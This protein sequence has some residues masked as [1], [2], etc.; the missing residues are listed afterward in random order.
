MLEPAD[1]RS[2]NGNFVER[3]G[4]LY[5]TAAQ[6]GSDWVT[7][8][9][10]VIY[11]YTPATD[12]YT[13]LLDLND[14]IRNP[15]WGMVEAADGRL[16][17]IAD[18]DSSHAWGSLASGTLYAYDIATNTLEQRI[19]LGTLPFNSTGRAWPALMAAS[20][21]RLYGSFEQGLFE[22][23]P[24]TNTLA[25][26]AA[27][28]DGGNG[29]GPL[30]ALIE[31]CRKPNYKPTTSTAFAVCNGSYFTYDLRN[32]N[33]TGV[34]WRH[35]GTVAPEQTGQR[36][37]FDAIA[38]GDAGTW[39]CTLTN[40]C[41]TTQPPA[42]TITVGAGM[43]TSPVITG[44]TVLCGTNDAVVLSAD[45]SGVW[46]TGEAGTSITVTAPGD[47][48]LHTQQ[49]CG[50]AFSNILHVVHLDSVAAQV[51]TM[52]GGALQDTITW[53]PGDAI[54]LVG[55]GPGPWGALPAGTWSTGSEAPS[56][57]VTEQGSYSV[58][59]ANAC[60]ADT[61]NTVHV[62]PP[63]P[64]PAPQVVYTDV[65]GATAD[66]LLCTGESVAIGAPPGANYTLLQHGDFVASLN[67]ISTYATSDAGTYQVVASG[68]CQF[69]SDTVTISIT[70]DDAVPTSATI[71]P[72]TDVL[73]GCDQ[74]EV[75]LGHAEPQ[76]Y[77]LWM[78]G[79]GM[80]QQ[81]TTDHLLVD[82]QV[83]AYALI[84]Y[85]GCGDGAQDVITLSPLPAP[86]VTFDEPVMLWCLIDGPIPLTT[87][88]PDGG[89]YSG[90]GV[91][92]GY[93][94]PSAAGIG[95]HVLTYSVT[96]G[97]CTGYATDTI[98]VEACGGVVAA[99]RPLPVELH[100]VPND[101]TFIL[102]MGDTGGTVTL[103]AMDGKRIG[104]AFRLPP[105]THRLDLR[106]LAAGTYVVHVIADDGRAA[107]PRFVVTP[108]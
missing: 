43:A 26:R 70:V 25:L 15:V 12:T 94:T 69:T 28:P 60:N 104:P 10:G 56:I 14:S 27:L 19:D 13:K 45:M 37:T 39:A 95:T 83:Q 86:E 93:F 81:D 32:V 18:N 35:N 47:H 87:G 40:A 17:G 106:P 48:Q 97:T 20:N 90:P 108:P 4:L 58:I 11:S 3:D 64:P 49:A 99:A 9:K 2:P 36:L 71:L 107:F 24:A 54:E 75:Y 68:V 101:G 84:S 82:W 98:M 66:A 103:L 61:S 96:I 80:Q 78:D 85:N 67:D 50:A 89:S 73:Q 72:D 63:P 52:P 55:N 57:I 62:L 1:G 16:Y 6:G 38:A 59:V 33:A 34:V 30:S 5:S 53:C 65:S 41:G 88:S 42:I 102:S 79:Q 44:D 74:D 76:G 22:Y 92:D 46:D 29:R 91:T 31:I 51:V 23:D 8:P 21:G 100:P 77:W 7:D 105:G